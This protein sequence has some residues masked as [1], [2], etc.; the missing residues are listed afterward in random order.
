MRK[1]YETPKSSIGVTPSD[2]KR[3]KKILK[4]KEKLSDFG[5]EAID[6]MLWFRENEVLTQSDQF[7]R[8]ENLKKDVDQ[9]KRNLDD[10]E[11]QYK[12]LEQGLRKIKDMIGAKL[13]AKG[14]KI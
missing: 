5:R 2:R 7:H 13:K 3:I 6:K 1:K 11:G 12:N 9:L 4:P 8:I 10:R 14:Y